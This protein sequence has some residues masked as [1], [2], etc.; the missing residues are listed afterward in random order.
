MGTRWCVRSG[1]LLALLSVGLWCSPGY[2]QDV[3]KPKLDPS[4]CKQV[5]TQIDDLVSISQSQA[6]SREEKIDALSK[7]WAKSLSTMQDNAKRDDEMAK[8]VKELSESVGKVLGL[9]LN[10]PGAKQDQ[11]SPDAH[12]AMDNLNEQIKPYLS[13]MKILCP[14]LIMPK[15]MAK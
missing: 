9:A 7:S 5:Q 11:V 1:F 13:F 2:G 12:Q 6:M 8:M 4:I 15:V 10:S 14:D 3:V